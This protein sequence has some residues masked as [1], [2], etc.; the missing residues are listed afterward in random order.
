MVLNI[1]PLEQSLRKLASRFGAVSSNRENTIVF[2]AMLK[3]LR[4]TFD[5]EELVSNPR[6][7]CK[8][9]ASASAFGGKEC[10]ILLGA[11]NCILELFQGRLSSRFPQETTMQVFQCHY[12][13]ER[14]MSGLYFD[15]IKD[16]LHAASQGA[17]GFSCKPPSCLNPRQTPGRTIHLHF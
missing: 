8:K 17:S 14:L 6:G 16:V 11:C 4:F 9:G 7:L 3:S 12:Q 5:H 13:E 2:I 15:Y 10:A 1:Y